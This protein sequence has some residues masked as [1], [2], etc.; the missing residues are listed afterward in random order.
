MMHT[1]K[2][3]NAQQYVQGNRSKASTGIMLRKSFNKIVLPSPTTV[4]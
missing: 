4:E 1:I 3:Y 2:P